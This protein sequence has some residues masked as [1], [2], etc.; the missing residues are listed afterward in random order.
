MLCERS[1]ASFAGERCM[2]ALLLQI[3]DVGV[4]SLTSRV[5][6]DRDWP[7]CDLGDGISAIVAVLAEAARND[8]SAQDHKREE[9]DQH[10]YS[11]PDEVFYVLE[12]VRLPGNWICK[13]ALGE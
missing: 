1:M 7:G 3:G 6:G 13:T 4:T 8:G 2:F 5:A 12:H 9:R 11:E 10:D